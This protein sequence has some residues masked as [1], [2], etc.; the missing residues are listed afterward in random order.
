MVASC[1]V[2]F[3]S[4]QI[5]ATIQSYGTPQVGAYIGISN[6]ILIATFIYAIAPASGGH[7]NPLITFSAMLTGL[8]SVPRGMLATLSA[9]DTT[10]TSRRL[11]VNRHAVARL[12]EN[13]SHLLTTH[14]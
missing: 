7:I 11:C 12:F 9:Y 14:V 1:C 4:G 10:E 8:C 5:A 13:Q 3:L 2:T 6:L